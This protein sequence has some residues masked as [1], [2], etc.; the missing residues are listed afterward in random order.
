MNRDHVAIPFL[1]VPAL[2]TARF[3][4]IAVEIVTGNPGSVFPDPH[5]GSVTRN[6]P[7]VAGLTNPHNDQPMGMYKKVFHRTLHVQATRLELRMV[8]PRPGPHGLL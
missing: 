4:R 6:R 3:V 1:E 5:G 2:I 8:S 7:G